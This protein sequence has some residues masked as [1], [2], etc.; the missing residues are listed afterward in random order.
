M[1]TPLPD[2]PATDKVGQGNTRMNE[3]RARINQVFTGP[4]APPHAVNRVW[5][6][7]PV[8]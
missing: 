4:T 2:V 6:R 5:I 7:P 3:E 1:S 8:S